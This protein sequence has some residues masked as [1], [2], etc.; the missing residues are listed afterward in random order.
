[1]GNRPLCCKVVGYAASRH[2]QR[3]P[4]NKSVVLGVVRPLVDASERILEGRCPYLLGG[5]V[6]RREA[7]FCGRP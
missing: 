4:N 3:F 5:Q 1:V 7:N 6:N 2:D